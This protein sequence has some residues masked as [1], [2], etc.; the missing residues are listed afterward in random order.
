[1]RGQNPARSVA[2]GKG[3]RG[4]SYFVD[5]IDWVGGYPFEVAK[6]KEIFDFFRAHEFVLE[7]LKTSGRGHTC[8]EFVLFDAT[9]VFYLA[10]SLNMT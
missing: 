4:L 5:L 7:R 9:P 6:P 1:V 8:N 10:C 2:K 3:S